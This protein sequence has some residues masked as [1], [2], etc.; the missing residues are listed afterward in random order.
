LTEIASALKDYMSTAQLIPRFDPSYSPSVVRAIA[1]CTAAISALDA[2]ICVSPIARP[3]RMRASWSGYTTALRLQGVEID[4]ID[5]F[6]WGCGLKLPGRPI[7]STTLDPFDAFDP[8]QHRLAFEQGPGWRDHLP[9]AIGEPAEASEHP[10]L[11]RA[12]E[13]LRQRS[14][15]DPTIQAWLSAP[16]MFAGLKLTSAPL[17]CFVGGAK[18]FRLKRSLAEADWVA[19]MNALTDAARTALERLDELE[20]QYRRGLRALLIEYRPGALPRLLALAQAR[21][22]LS[23]QR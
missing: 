16:L 4:E 7:I 13:L 12:L 9:T 18:A 15:I 3:W 10:P 23:P 11:I 5:V 22:M 8:W 19:A 6:S 1:H 2:R 17:P 14:R 20:L 21:P